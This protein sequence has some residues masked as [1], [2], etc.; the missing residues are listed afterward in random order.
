MSRGQLA[1]TRENFP[2]MNDRAGRR[3]ARR[4]VRREVA[5]LV[6]GAQAVQSVWAALGE[7]AMAFVDAVADGV[8]AFADSFVRRQSH[9]RGGR[10]DYILVDEVGGGDEG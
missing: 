5:D 9:A 1:R 7:T 4:R 2:R 10:F 6:A 3:R 8:R